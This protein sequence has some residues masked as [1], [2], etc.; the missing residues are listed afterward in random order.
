MS[1]ICDLLRLEMKT[2]YVLKQISY[3]VCGPVRDGPWKPYFLVHELEAEDLEGAPKDKTL[4]TSPAT[5]AMIS[6]TKS[7]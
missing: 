3:I 4:G 5:E 2:Y 1:V 6:L 7:L